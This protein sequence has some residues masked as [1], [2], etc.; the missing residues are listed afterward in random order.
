MVGGAKFQQNFLEWSKQST[1]LFTLVF[2]ALLVTWVLFAEKLPMNWRYQLS[3]TAG[4]ALLLILLYLVNEYLGWSHALILTIAIAMTWANRPLYKPVSVKE[5][6]AGSVKSSPKEGSELWFVEKV[7]QENP[8]GIV[9]ERV[10]TS[11]VQQ[12]NGLGSNRTSR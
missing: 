11:A 4:R 1:N 8:K 7:L 10:E 2:D 3:T 12:D 5:G 6:F 9:E